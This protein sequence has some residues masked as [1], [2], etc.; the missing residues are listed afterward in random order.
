MNLLKGFWDRP[1]RSIQPQHG[2]PCPL[3][4]RHWR[5][6]RNAEQSPVPPINGPPKMRKSWLIRGAAQC[7]GKIKE[8]TVRKKGAHELC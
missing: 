6:P 7:L 3:L 4:P 5:V 8:E 1:R 2:K